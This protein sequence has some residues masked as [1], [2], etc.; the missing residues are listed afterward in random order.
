M[1]SL[2]GGMR[3]HE[4]GVLEVQSHPR[5]HT[6][7]AASVEVSPNYCRRGMLTLC[8]VSWATWLTV[9]GSLTHKGGD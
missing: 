4:K 1:P 5:K 7:P 8:A 9:C 2:T 3:Q 6:F